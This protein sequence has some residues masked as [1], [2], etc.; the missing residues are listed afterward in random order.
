MDS[1]QNAPKTNTIQ[2]TRKTNDKVNLD[3]IQ[4]K[5]N[6]PV[7]KKPYLDILGYTINVA[8]KMT[9]FAKPNQIIIGEE[10]HRNLDNQT[11]R[12]FEKLDI[13]N[14]EWN[15]INNSTGNTYELF[16]N[17]RTQREFLV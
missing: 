4:K 13:E 9:N 1:I 16:V 5:N 17:K 14:I 8:T 11:K 7:D 3:K 15:Y 10:V 6:I 12:K 2:R